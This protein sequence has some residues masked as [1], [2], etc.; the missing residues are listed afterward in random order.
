MDKKGHLLLNYTRQ[1]TKYIQ[2]VWKL[3]LVG[4]NSNNV[5]RLKKGTY[6]R[7]STV[8]NDA[9]VAEEKPFISR[10]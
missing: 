8:Y 4:E 7:S 6:Q 10:R 9:E 2:V 5:G 3:A 1:K